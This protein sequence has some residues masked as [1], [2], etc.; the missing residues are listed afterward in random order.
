MGVG[1]A[2]AAPN[3][4]ARLGRGG[5]V[6]AVVLPHGAHHLD[7]MFADPAD[8]PDVRAARDAELSAV[9]AWSAQ[10]HDEQRRARTAS[11]GVGTGVG[12]EEL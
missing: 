10:W 8:P 1:A 9:A 3:N 7:L 2:A 4:T 5:S 12:V 6:L 11:A